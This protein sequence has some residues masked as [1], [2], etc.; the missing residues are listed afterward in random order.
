VAPQSPG[1]R[2]PLSTGAQHESSLRIL[3]SLASRVPH[4]DSSGL[5]QFV[6]GLGSS[7]LGIP[8]S[9]HESAFPISFGGKALVF[10]RD[11]QGIPCRDPTPWSSPL[12]LPRLPRAT[13][14]T[15]RNLAGVGRERQR[16]RS[17]RVPAGLELPFSH[18]CEALRLALDF[19]RL[20]TDERGARPLSDPCGI[21][22]SQA[23]LLPMDALYV[24]PRGSGT[25]LRRLPGTRGWT[26]AIEEV[27]SF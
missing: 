27:S 13:R 25:A 12:K 8:V 21:T 22:V 7:A 17:R 2:G 15:A 23:P 10:T 9:A 4:R 6:S 26:E 1:L 18:L 16:G 3:T 20:P 5:H 14:L 11:H 19:M 24:A